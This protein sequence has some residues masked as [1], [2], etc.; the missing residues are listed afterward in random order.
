[1]S[2]QSY[3]YRSICSWNMAARYRSVSLR[4]VVVVRIEP[5]Q[6]WSKC[7]LLVAIN[8]QMQAEDRSAPTL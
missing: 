2:L 8:R 3:S 7:A 6:E 4:L 5:R 1:M